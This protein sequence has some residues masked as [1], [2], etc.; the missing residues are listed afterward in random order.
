MPDA[1]AP[2]DLADG[3]RD[4]AAAVGPREGAILLA[5]A[6][7]VDRH[8]LFAADR[9][10]PLEPAAARRFRRLLRARRGGAPIAYLTGT[11]AFWDMSLAVEPGVLV[12]RPETERIVEEVRDAFAG[13]SGT[14][15]IADVGTGTGAIAIAIARAL[16]HAR[17]VA[18]DRSAHALRL[19]ARNAAD[20]APGVRLLPPGDLLAPVARAGVVA[21]AVVMN[22]P[23]V[24][25]RDW[26]RLP[27]DVRR[28]PRSA[29]DGGPDGL[30]VVRRLVAAIARGEGVR[31]G[32][33][34]WIE[35][36]AGQARAARAL[37]ARLGGPTE[38]ALDLAGIERV[39]AGQWQP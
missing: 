13:A 29:L 3:L 20:W 25:T 28:E 30:G 18:T 4:G 12:P 39:V 33:R 14:P 23:Y 7:G 17:V 38:V 26:R 15:L 11:A 34:V 16:P 32:T 2:R 19:A 37:L 24:A 27:R 21:D 8:A 5:H 35:V 36:G 9:A 31:P 1:Q 6:L 10:V 22:P